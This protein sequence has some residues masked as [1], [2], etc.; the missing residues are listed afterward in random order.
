M[1]RLFCAD[2]MQRTNATQNDKL[3]NKKKR[4]KVCDTGALLNRVFS[5]ASF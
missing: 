4:L 5:I 1:L 2:D 3:R